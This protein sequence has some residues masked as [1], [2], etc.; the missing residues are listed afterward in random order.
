MIIDNNNDNDSNDSN[1][2]N[3]NTNTAGLHG[4]H[5]YMQDAL[6]KAVLKH[7][8]QQSLS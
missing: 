5:G 6:I 7:L 4:Y 3:N 2:G 1:S 8:S